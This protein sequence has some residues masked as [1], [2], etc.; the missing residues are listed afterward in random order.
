MP[1]LSKI[2]QIQSLPQ[3]N[4]PKEVAPYTLE[5]SPSRGWRNALTAGCSG[6]GLH[7][8]SSDLI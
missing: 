3:A 4:M 2:R 7:M 5:M 1:R 6:E 8:A